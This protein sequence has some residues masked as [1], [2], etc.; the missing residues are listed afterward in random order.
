MRACAPTHPLY[1]LY[2]VC[3]CSQPRRK[4]LKMGCVCVKETERVFKTSMNIL[5][6]AQEPRRR[7]GERPLRDGG[8]II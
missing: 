8:G 1:L 2:A 5:R 7:E 3:G 4:E 6:G